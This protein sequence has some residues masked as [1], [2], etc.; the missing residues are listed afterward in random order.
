MV[1]LPVVPA[2]SEVPSIESLICQPSLLLPWVGLGEP[3]LPAT[4]LLRAVVP[5][6]RGWIGFFSGSM[7]AID[8]IWD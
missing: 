3:I 1:A 5:F 7:G 2:G 8:A 4:D 6:S